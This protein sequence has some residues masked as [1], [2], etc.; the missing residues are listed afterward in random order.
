MF[1]TTENAGKYVGKTLDSSKRSFH[2]Y[3]LRVIRHS[4]GGYYYVDRLNT[5]IPVQS[6]KD[7]FN[8]VWFDVVDGE[9]VEQCPADPISR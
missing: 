9:A 4:N 7:S 8:S 6:E 3:P 5:M 1:L 2:Y